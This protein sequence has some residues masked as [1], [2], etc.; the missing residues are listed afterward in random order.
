MASSTVARAEHGRPVNTLDSVR[1]RQAKASLDGQSPSIALTSVV[2]DALQ[3]HYGSL[4]A[5][6]ISLRMDQGQLTR[7][8]QTGDF[9]LEKLERADDDAK[10][11]I[12]KALH[13]ACGDNDPRA[14][15]RRLIR[16]ARARLDELAEVV[17]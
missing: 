3:R 10:A 2:R 11:F 8:L 13:E 16:E 12:A 9:K 17:A 1:P 15:A 6:A 14:Q 4:K 5:A 7:E